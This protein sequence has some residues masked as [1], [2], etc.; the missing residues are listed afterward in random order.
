MGLPSSEMP[1]SRHSWEMFSLSRS[2][3]TASSGYACVNIPYFGL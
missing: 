2:R 1:I 3:R